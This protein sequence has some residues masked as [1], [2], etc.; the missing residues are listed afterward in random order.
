MRAAVVAGSGFE[1]AD[2]PDPA[3]GPT[4]LVLRVAA[5][6]ICGS[7]IKS[8]Q[9]MPAGTVMGH[10]MAG[11]VVAAGGQVAAAWPVGTPVAALPVIGC[12]S[13]PPCAVGDVARCVSAD[14]LGLGGS[15]G[16]FAEYVRVGARES[17]RLPESALLDVAAL[18]EPLA[19]GLHA[20]SRARIAPGE[21]VLVVGAGPVGLAVLVWARRAGATQLVVSD[22]AGQR[23]E[24]AGSFGATAAVDPLHEELG[25]PYDVVIEC[26]GVPGVLQPC[27]DAVAV[28]GRV[29]VAGVC[30][31]PDPFVPVGAVLKEVEMHFVSYYT[32]A[33]FAATAALLTS[34]QL[35]PGPFVTG[36]LGLADAAQAFTDLAGPTSNRK[37]LLVP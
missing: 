8:R 24:A 5:C 21:R 4:D 13:C 2:I 36:R 11:E 27:V 12:G 34:G 14:T 25:G 33:E 28:H 30:M 7:D 20:V 23:R 37:V 32:M 18:V 10:E 16:G 9:Y 35:D 6:G 1:V 29:V 3:P 26:A 22:P 31:A 15:A 17:V 19:V